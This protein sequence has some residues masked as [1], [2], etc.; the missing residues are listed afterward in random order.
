MSEQV[1]VQE[2]AQAAPFCWTKQ[3]GGIDLGVLQRCCVGTCKALNSHSVAL[4]Y[5]FY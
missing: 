4:Q 1:H 5:S 2:E 3:P